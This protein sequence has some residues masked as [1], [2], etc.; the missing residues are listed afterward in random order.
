MFLRPPAQAPPRTPFKD[1]HL[2][3]ASFHFSALHPSRPACFYSPIFL[4]LLPFSP[5]YHPSHS[6]PS[7]QHSVMA[8][9]PFPHVSDFVPTA[10]TSPRNLVAAMNASTHLDENSTLRAE[11]ASLRAELAREKK[12]RQAAEEHVLEMRRESTL[13]QIRIEEEEEMISNKLM[14][15]LSELKQEKEQ[16]ARASESDSEWVTNSL[17]LRLEELQRQKHR[18]IAAAEEENEFIVN[19]LNKELDALRLEKVELERKVQRLSRSTTPGAV[20]PTSSPALSFRSN[21]GN[22]SRNSS[23]RIPYS[24]NAGAHHH[25]NSERHA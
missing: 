11:L 19:R 12:R 3:L 5:P 10:S 24:N 21:D 14:K 18:I 22:L 17:S 15:R 4:A 9:V 8:H 1:S 23:Y 13:N 2:L 16:I 25:Q 7:Q 6:T 20:T